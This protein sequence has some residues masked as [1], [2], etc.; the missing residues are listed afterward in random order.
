RAIKIG[1]FKEDILLLLVIFQ[2]EETT[3]LAGCL[4]S[5]VIGDA[6]F[7]PVTWHMEGIRNKSRFTNTALLAAKY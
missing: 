5:L 3:F 4:R 1:R 6:L 2:V 7:P